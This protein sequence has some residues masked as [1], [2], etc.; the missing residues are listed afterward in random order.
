MKLTYSDGLLFTTLTITHSGKEK[1][2]D[3]VVI[4]TGASHTIISPDAVAD[5]GIFMEHG[6][7]IVTSYG[8]GGKQYAFVKKID[9]VKFSATTVKSYQIDFGI[10]DPK[11]L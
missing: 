4:D 8:I 2:I 6:D 10:V 9:K 3:G 5:I 7:H 11:I 1:L